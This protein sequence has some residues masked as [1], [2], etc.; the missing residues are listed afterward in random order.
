MISFQQGEDPRKANPTGEGE[1]SLSDNQGQ[2]AGAIGGLLLL[3]SHKDLTTSA[4]VQE[5]DP[6]SAAMDQQPDQQDAGPRQQDPSSLTK[7]HRSSSP[8][9]SS[10]PTSHVIAV[11][12]NVPP[13]TPPRDIDWDDLLNGG[14]RRMSHAERLDLWRYMLQNRP[15]PEASSL[16]GS[17]SDVGNPRALSE[18]L[19]RILWLSDQSNWGPVPSEPVVAAAALSTSHTASQHVSSQQEDEQ[20][21]EVQHQQEQEVEE[22]PKTEVVREVLDEKSGLDLGNSNRIDEMDKVMVGIVATE[23]AAAAA[24]DGT[25]VERERQLQQQEDVEDRKDEDGTK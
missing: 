21:E 15:S 16:D 18:W 6:P 7:Q 25:L 11:A 5:E 20:E 8:S 2:Q 24:L 23:A 4:T 3:N 17:P 1:T 19:D 22:E 13:P 14:L 12:S 10:S 9:S